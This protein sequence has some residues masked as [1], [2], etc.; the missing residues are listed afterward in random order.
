MNTQPFYI[1][2]GHPRIPDGS[3][4]PFLTYSFDSMVA[5]YNGIRNDANRFSRVSVYQLKLEELNL[6]L[7]AELITTL[8]F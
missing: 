5:Q 4:N 8:S 2:I 3:L 1:V 6:E 7:K